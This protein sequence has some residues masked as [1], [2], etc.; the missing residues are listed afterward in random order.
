MKAARDAPGFLDDVRALLVRTRNNEITLSEFER[1]FLSLHAEMPSSTPETSAASIEALFWSVEA[2]VA[3]PSLRSGSDLDE[4]ALREA[5]GTCLSELEPSNRGDRSS[6]VSRLLDEVQEEFDF[7]RVLPLYMFAWT[8]A[9]F[10]MDR[11]DPEFVTTCEA[12]YTA[13]MGRHP[14]LALVWVP[15]PIDLTRYR[16]VEPGTAIEL[17]ADAPVN[18]SLL[19]LVAPEDLPG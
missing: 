18:T 8:L 14:D 2:F 12:A 5:I 1:E 11:S 19:V 7:D 17:D 13:F 4:Q 15:W 9:G 16:P 6:L 10:G 3:A